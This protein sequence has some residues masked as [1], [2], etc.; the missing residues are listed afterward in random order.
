MMMR[1]LLPFV[2]ATVLLGEALP[3][4][5][6]EEAHSVDALIEDFT[7]QPETRWRFFT[8]AVMGGVS[9]GQVV[10]AQEDGRPHA[11]MTG[12]VST[13]NRAGVGGPYGS[14]STVRTG[15]PPTPNGPGFVVPSGR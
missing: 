14:T 11:R 12:R 5:L 15:G 8:D 6:A 10:F 2:F 1:G 9:S 13:A 3:A 7:M 4:A